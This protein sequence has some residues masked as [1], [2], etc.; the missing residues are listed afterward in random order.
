MPVSD[1]GN[2]KDLYKIIPRTLIFITNEEHL[3]L[4]KGAPDKRLWANLYNGIGGHI[5]RGEDPLRAARRELF[6]ET[7][8]DIPNLRLSGVISID[9]GKD[10]GI[11][12]YV[13]KAESSSKDL[14]TSSEGDLKWVAQDRIFNLPLV[15]DLYELLPIILNKKTN[16]SPFSALFTYNENGQISIVFS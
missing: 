15:E 7:G 3:L 6:E 13:F 9:T 1:Q 4:L 10:T 8:L 12:I 11:G 2:L 5:E 14:S 16:D